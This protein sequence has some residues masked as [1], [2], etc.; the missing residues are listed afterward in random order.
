M[1]AQYITHCILYLFSCYGADGL[2]LVQVSD[3]HFD[4]GTVEW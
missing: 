1:Y 2:T 4:K 3:E